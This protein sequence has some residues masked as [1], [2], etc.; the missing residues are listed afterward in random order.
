MSA[1]VSTNFRTKFSKR[2][3]SAPVKGKTTK[4]IVPLSEVVKLQKQTVSSE[5]NNKGEDVAF[6][7]TLVTAIKKFNQ[8]LDTI[9]RQ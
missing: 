8:R 9:K 7:Q 3:V 4:H 1:L 2:E 5:K 6:I